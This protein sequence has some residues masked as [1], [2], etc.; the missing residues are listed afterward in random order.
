M[1]VRTKSATN[2]RARAPHRYGPFTFSNSLFFI[3]FCS[4]FN[5]LIALLLS[6][7][8]VYHAQPVAAD[9]VRVRASLADP[10]LRL[11]P[12]AV[13]PL[14][15]YA[16]PSAHQLMGASSVAG[17]LVVNVSEIGGKPGAHVTS[18]THKIKVRLLM[19]SLFLI[20]FFL[21]RPVASFHFIVVIPN[22][23]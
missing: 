21:L 15:F 11:Y 6:R 9:I 1:K 23:S 19:F 7:M 18:P 2:R 13:A 5:T 22:L 3:S 10:R 8:Y 12:R 17:G 14:A 16:R 20:L 4:F